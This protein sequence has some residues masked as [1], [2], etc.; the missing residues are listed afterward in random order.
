MFPGDYVEM[1]ENF[2]DESGATIGIKAGMYGKILKIDHEGDVLVDFEGLGQRWLV[3]KETSSLQVVFVESPSER[4]HMSSSAV[5]LAARQTVQSMPPPTVPQPAQSC[6]VGHLTWDSIEARK[7]KL[8]RELETLQ[9]KLSHRSFHNPSFS[10]GDSRLQSAGV[11]DIAM[12]LPDVTKTPSSSPSPQLCSNMN[13]N[14]VKLDV[15]QL[16][17]AC[18]DWAA[19]LAKN[20]VRANTNLMASFLAGLGSKEALHSSITAMGVPISP[21]SAA[22][23]PAVVVNPP[24]GSEAGDKY[25]PCVVITFSLAPEEKASVQLRPKKG[26][27]VIKAKRSVMEK[28]GERFLAFFGRHASLDV[29]GPKAKAVTNAPSIVDL[30]R[31]HQGA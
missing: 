19:D 4:T 23:L 12:K 13:L 9:L 11:A 3:Q 24:F 7:E 15:D 17:Q 26:L 25:Q 1:K 8:R 28:H 21:K 20:P 22:G 18:R 2:D 29:N 31:F 16:C 6:K 27:V 5:A 30:L 10:H 14:F